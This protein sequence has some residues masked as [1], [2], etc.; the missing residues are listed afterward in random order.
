MQSYVSGAS[1]VPLIGQT[2]G[3]NLERTVARVPDREAIVSCHQGVRLTYA[4][5]DAQVD[6][7]ARGL[8]DL[9]LEKGDRV[10]LWSPNY[11]E[12]VLVQYATAKIG[13]ILVNLNPAYRTHELRV[14]ARPVGVPA[15]GRGPVVQD[16]RLPGHARRGAP[17]A[18][19]ARAGRSSS[20]RRSG[21][22]C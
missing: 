21:T 22:P 20:G 19:A 10:G 18:G 9:G 8:L 15:G 1:S 7:V 14:R 13:V 3:A 12:W 16:Q 11:V 2:I 6:L 5:L 17:R 4:E